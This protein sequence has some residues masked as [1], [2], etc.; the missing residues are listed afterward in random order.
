MKIYN[1][2]KQPYY[3][4]IKNKVVLETTGN[5]LSFENDFVYNVAKSTG[6]KSNKVRHI[7]KRFKLLILAALD[8]KIEEYKNENNN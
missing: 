1:T 8:A 7:K 4:R 6:L 2:Y 5:I 3:G